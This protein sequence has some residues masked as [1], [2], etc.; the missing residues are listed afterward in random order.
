[1]AQATRHAS[2]AEVDY[3]PGSAVS[4]GDVVVVGSNLVGIA[5][6]AIAANALG[7][8][9]TEG[10]FDIVKV[11]GSVSAG[12]SIYWDADGDP[13]GGTAGSGAATATATGNTYLGVALADA[14]SGGAT[15]RVLKTKQPAI[16]ANNALASIIADPGDGEA[17][18]VTV[19]GSVS[20]V[21]AGAETRTLADPTFVGQQLSLGFKTDGGDVV[22]TSAS[23]VNQ[24]GNNTLTFADVGDHLQLTAIEDGSDIEWRVVANDGVALSTV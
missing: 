5:N 2:G 8:L 14:V 24:T 23:P 4:A 16:T 22:V 15:V 13:V 11:T 10:V 18:P 21:S 20:L 1:M 12:A 6:R 19:S 9:A 7:A 3:T 17:I